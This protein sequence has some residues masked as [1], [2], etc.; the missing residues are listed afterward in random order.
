MT[1]DAF[2]LHNTGNGGFGEV[3]TVVGGTGQWARARGAFRALGVFAG[4]SG[5]GSY[6]G[7]ICLP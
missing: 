4:G 6:V 7:E 1:K 5:K 3:D 2:V